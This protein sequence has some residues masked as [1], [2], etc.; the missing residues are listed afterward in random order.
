[1]KKVYGLFVFLTLFQATMFSQF[2]WEDLGGQDI[3]DLAMGQRKIW[4]AG[5]SGIYYYD[6]DSKSWSAKMNLPDPYWPH[7]Y[8]KLAANDRG[9]VAV[10]NFYERYFYFSENNGQLWD[11]ISL[12]PDLLGIFEIYFLGENIF[13]LSE[14]ALRSTDKGKH[15]VDLYKEQDLIQTNVVYF[16]GNYYMAGQEKLYISPDDG[17]TWNET[18]Q[19]FKIWAL[20]TYGED[21]FAVS[22]D[23]E[24]TY[25]LYISKDGVN[26]TYAGDGFPE[27]YPISDFDNKKRQL[28]YRDQDHYYLFD[29]DPLHRT[30][31]SP[32][33][34][35]KWTVIPTP[36]IPVDMLFTPDKI[37]LGHEGLY[38]NTVE[39]P[40]I[41]TSTEIFNKSS[42]SS[43][44]LS[45]NPAGNLLHL[46][47]NDLNSRGNLQIFSS[48]GV[49]LKSEI[50]TENSLEFE[51]ED[52]LPGA[53]YA[54]FKNGKN[55]S[56][57]SFVKSN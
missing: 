20:S 26:W 28:I 54:F 16:K 19:P 2:S 22:V 7:E 39:N 21:L 8:N 36:I 15:W 13:I 29:A 30:Y 52:L 51:I 37:Y 44:T 6:L 34:P 3:F 40:Y 50:V 12:D 41:I 11:T 57:K 53:Y 47:F 49:M 4:T 42:E 33:D 14:V 35:V 17:I 25:I 38:Q 43:F 55:E 48:A 27:L 5:H 32:I 18:P 1:M 56:I 46:E 45:P 10:S 31:S 9:W 24:N 23:K